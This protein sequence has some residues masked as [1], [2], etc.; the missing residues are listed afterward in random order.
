MKRLW[1]LIAALALS[2][3]GYNESQQKDAP[4]QRL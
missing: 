3:C 4:V 1:I 2:G